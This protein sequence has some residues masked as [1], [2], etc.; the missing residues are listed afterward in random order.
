MANPPVMTRGPRAGAWGSGRFWRDA[1][2]CPVIPHVVRKHD[3]ISRAEFVERKALI[4]VS[5][6]SP[7]RILPRVQMGGNSNTCSTTEPHSALSVSMPHSQR[8]ESAGKPCSVSNRFAS[9]LM[10]QLSSAK[11]SSEKRPGRKVP[12]TFFVSSLYDFRPAL[13]SKLA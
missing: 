10:G 3:V 4:T 9:I 5:L 11:N 6:D 13:V 2:R 8:L 1:P 12:M 7:I